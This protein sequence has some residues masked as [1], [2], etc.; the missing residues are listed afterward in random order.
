MKSVVQALLRMRLSGLLW[1]IASAV[2]FLLGSAS[3]NGAGVKQLAD[4][5]VGCAIAAIAVIIAFFS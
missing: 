4:L 1:L 2:L 5:G 3:F